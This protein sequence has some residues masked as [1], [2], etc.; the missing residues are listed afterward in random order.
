MT[1]EESERLFPAVCH[2]KVIAVDLIGLQERLNG[3]LMD[4][5]VYDDKFR[6][7]NRSA[8]GKYVCFDASIRVE[9]HS[10]MK[11]IDASLRSL[12]GIKMV[13]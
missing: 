8:H 2:F 1:D 4:L 9:S 12:D 7:G 13:L 11:L 5:G 10:Q 6:P 3:V